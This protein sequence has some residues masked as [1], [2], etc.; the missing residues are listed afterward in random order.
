VVPPGVEEGEL[1]FVEGGQGEDLERLEA[2]L[3]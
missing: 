2:G 1:G 3:L